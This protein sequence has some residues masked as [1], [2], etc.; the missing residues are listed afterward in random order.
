MNLQTPS[1]NFTD[2]LVAAT[3]GLYL[4]GDNVYS[5][6]SPVAAPLE[7]TVLYKFALSATAFEPTAWGKV[8]GGLQPYFTT[9]SR[10]NA[11]QDK[12]RVI[13]TDGS[14]EHRFFVLEENSETSRLEVVGALPNAEQPLKLASDDSIYE[15]ISAGEMIYVSTV[16]GLNPVLSGVTLSPAGPT[17]V[18]DTSDPAA[19]QLVRQLFLGDYTSYI[20]PLTQEYFLA[21]SR[22]GLG[23]MGAQISLWDG[24]AAAPVASH[25]FSAPSGMSGSGGPVTN[26]PAN[27]DSRSVVVEQG[28][29]GDFRVAVPLDFTA[30]VDQKVSARSE[31]VFLEVTGLPDKPELNLL[32][33]TESHVYPCAD[34]FNEG[35]GC[36][37]G[38]L[39][40]QRRSI[41]LEDSLFYFYEGAASVGPTGITSFS[42]GNFSTL[43]ERIAL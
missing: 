19:P 22:A 8:A 9:G 3:Q 2:C 21:I 1:V 28:P 37:Y 35:Y 39:R 24:S 13:T 7:K 20:R 38:Y 41:L 12:L 43:V 32:G 5:W 26:S 31:V 29:G 27:Y 18:I 33:R 25:S 14:S 10:V 15:A 23:G 6:A 42:W 17:Y 36:I 40:S 11:H 16:R 34:S 4:D 30:R